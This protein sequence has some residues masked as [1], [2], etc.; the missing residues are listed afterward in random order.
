M[1]LKRIFQN[2]PKYQVDLYMLSA[3][4]DN[5]LNLFESNCKHNSSNIQCS[6]GTNKYFFFHT[7]FRQSKFRII[8][9][10]LLCLTTE[11]ANN[12]YLVCSVTKTLVT[13]SPHQNRFYSENDLVLVC[14]KMVFIPASTF[15]CMSGGG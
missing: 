9:S 7:K 2:Y 1:L 12:C 5:T 3:E 4:G 14:L 8:T 11:L 13:D 10:S 15:L 6:Q